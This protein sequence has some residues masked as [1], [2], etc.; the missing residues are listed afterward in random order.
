MLGEEYLPKVGDEEAQVYR[1]FRLWPSGWIVL[2]FAWILGFASV[3]SLTDF[4]KER[5]P[6]CYLVVEELYASLS[7]VMK[8]GVQFNSND[9]CK[10]AVAIVFSDP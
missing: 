1:S 2:L 5:E 7:D 6:Y 10:I 8:Q 4:Y 3:P 9:V